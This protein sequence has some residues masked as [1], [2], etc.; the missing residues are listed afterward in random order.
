MAKQDPVTKP[1]ALAT[2]APPE[3]T[4]IQA[5]LTIESEKI[6]QERAKLD[7]RALK[8]TEARKEFEAKLQAKQAA[9]QVT[10]RHSRSIPVIVQTRKNKPVR[11]RGD[12][13]IPCCTTVTVSLD[14][15]R[16]LQGYRKRGKIQLIVGKVESG[17]VKENP[18]K[19]VG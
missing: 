1:E 12:K 2:A 6:E 4:K 5:D 15:L 8:A 17:S 9:E 11:L 16:R 14:E 13:T 3:L 10:E 19:K 7:A 18:P